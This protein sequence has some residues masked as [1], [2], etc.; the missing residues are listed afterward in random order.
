MSIN[1]SSLNTDTHD[2]VLVYF[3]DYG[4][5]REISRG[6]IFEIPPEFVSVL[7]F[8]AIRCAL[9][10]VRTKDADAGWAEEAGDLLFELGAG[11]GE[12]DLMNMGGGGEEIDGE[13][14]F[15]VS[16]RGGRFEHELVRR[17]KGHI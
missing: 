15:S 2:E 6:K 13:K 5:E 17:G 12:V 4:F 8:Q 3:V 1:Q 16:V 11:N 10:N 14:V 7:P 9:H